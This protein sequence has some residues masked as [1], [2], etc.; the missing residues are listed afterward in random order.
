M[1]DLVCPRC[2]EKKAR[3]SRECRRCADIRRQARR[4]VE[5][6][7]RGERLVLR[8]EKAR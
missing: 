5:A 7:M 4:Y 6:V 2:G 1:S 3:R 8:F